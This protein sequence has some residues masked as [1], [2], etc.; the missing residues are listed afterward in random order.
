MRVALVEERMV[1]RVGRVPDPWAFSEHRYCG[2][3][4]WDDPE[5]NFRTIY[6]GD[7]L[8]ACYVEVLAPLRPDMPD[9]LGLLDGIGEDADD[10]LAY[11]TPAAGAIP[12]SWLEGRMWSKATL[13]GQFVDVTAAATI[14]DLRPRFLGLALSLGFS[15]FDA[16]A[17][18]TAHPRELTQR[19][20]ARLYSLRLGR[21]HANLNGVRFASRHGDDL[22]LWAIFEQPGDGAISGSVSNTDSGLVH[23]NDPELARALEH[24]ALRWV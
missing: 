19:V 3:N 9:S 13:S 14:R 20:A 11:P 1:Y 4:R 23:L 22:R 18:K 16:A 8:F 21:N 7:D 5:L 12:R 2:N 15:D 17:L 24:H 10:A 6:A